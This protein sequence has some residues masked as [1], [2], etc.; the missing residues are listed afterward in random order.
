MEGFMV[1][2]TWDIED[3]V[4]TR[5]S[6]LRGVVGRA[7][8]I[9]PKTWECRAGPEGIVLVLEIRDGVGKEEEHK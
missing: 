4:G 7:K 9:T 2:D 6:G 8:G 5:W 3:G 1:E